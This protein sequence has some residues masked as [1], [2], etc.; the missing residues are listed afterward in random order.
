MLYKLSLIDCEGLRAADRK[1]C[2]LKG[3]LLEV[4]VVGETVDKLAKTGNEKDSN[5]KLG[6]DAHQP[7]FILFLVCGKPL[8]LWFKIIIMFAKVL[9]KANLI[10]ICSILLPVWVGWLF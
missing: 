2:E 6:L 5:H 1:W 3:H 9:Y 8:S 10:C 4:K 7:T